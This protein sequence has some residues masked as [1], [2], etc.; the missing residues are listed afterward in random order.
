MIAKALDLLKVI[1][2]GATHTH[3]NPCVGTGAYTCGKQGA[4]GMHTLC[5]VL[6]SCRDGGKAARS[7]NSEH[8]CCANTAVER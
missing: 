4:V 7:V 6:L 3:V 8:C 1:G 2:L 5:I